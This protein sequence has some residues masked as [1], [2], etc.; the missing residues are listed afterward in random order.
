MVMNKEKG[1]RYDPALIE[2]ATALG[3]ELGATRAGRALGV[4][5][6]II[7]SWMRKKNNGRHMAVTDTP[8]QRALMEAKKE[9]HKLKRENGDL[10]K[11]NTILRE[12]ASF[13]SKD[14]PH[15]NS[16]WSLNSLVK[17]NQK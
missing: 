3:E 10:K 2:R 7:G 17:G 15:T 4:P 12:L 11:A 1:K 9:I 14:H 13:F 6:R 8:E 5:G 16:E